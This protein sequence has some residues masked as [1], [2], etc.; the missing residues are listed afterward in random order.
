MK[1]IGVGKNAK[2]KGQK[3]ISS[4]TSAFEKV[5]PTTNEDHEASPVLK[6]KEHKK[7]MEMAAKFQNPP[8][9]LQ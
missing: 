4:T 3:E 9:D 2:P 1:H 5:T 7:T 6:E 8:S